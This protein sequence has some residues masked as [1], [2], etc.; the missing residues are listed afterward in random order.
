MNIKYILLT[1]II[2]LVIYL[3]SYHNEYL[4]YDENTFMTLQAQQAQL[5]L[6]NNQYDNSIPKDE[7][8]T[9]D[10]DKRAEFVN[11]MNF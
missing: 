9:N 5:E 6:L 10:N 7:R 1:I 11:T 4:T 2:L 8:I 3:L